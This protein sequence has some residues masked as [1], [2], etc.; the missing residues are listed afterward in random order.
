M[1]KIEIKEYFGL[2]TK[3]KELVRLTGISPVMPGY[4]MII[5]AAVVYKIQGGKD[6]YNTVGEMM[7]VVPGQKPLT[8]KEEERHPVKQ[9]ILEAMRSVG[10]CDSVKSFIEELARQL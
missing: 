8:A 4:E 9:Q 3:A 2:Y 10:I 7:S 6:L 5:K 1:C